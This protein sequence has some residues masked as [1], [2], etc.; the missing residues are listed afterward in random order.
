MPN[1]TLLRNKILRRYTDLPGLIYLLK[2]Q[3][4]TLLDPQSWDD[5]NDS[6][7]LRLYREKKALQAV[8][9]LCF[10]QAS[11]TY[12][13]WRIFASGSSG[14]CISFRRRELLESVKGQTGLQAKSVKYLKLNQI[15]DRDLAV[16]DLPFLKRYAFENEDEFRMIYESKSDSLS[17]LDVAI[18][19][20][21]I[22]R[23]VLSPW[24]HEKL[25]DHV[26]DLLRSIDGCRG[27]KLARS[28]LISNEEWKELGQ[29]AI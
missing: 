17:S 6:Y 26:K 15:R 22:E 28:T 14:I 23:V 5:S 29:T 10:T 18:P 3:K 20:K 16:R 8:L 9:A 19:L 21:C 7:Y 25:S 1:T 4:I 27:V 2:E 11:E 24:I 13:H 12:H